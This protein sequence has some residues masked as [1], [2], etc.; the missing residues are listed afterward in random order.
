MVTVKDFGAACDGVTDDS[1][2]FQSA[3]NSV[4]NGST[5][6]FRIPDNSTCVVNTSPSFGTRVL[7]WLVQPG[8]Q[9]T[10]TGV[11][12][13]TVGSTGSDIPGGLTSRNTSLL[14]HFNAALNN[15]TQSVVLIGDSETQ[16]YYATNRLTQSWAALLTST[17]QSLYGNHGLGLIPLYDTANY[18]WTAN[19]TWTGSTTIGP[20]EPS[21]TISSVFSATGTGAAYS[22]TVS[23]SLSGLLA[24]SFTVLTY[25]ASDSGSCAV[26][27]DGGPATVLSHAPTTPAAPVTDVVAAGGLGYHSIAVGPNGATQK[28]YFAGVIPT[29]GTTGLQVSNI[30]ISGSRTD[31]YG[32]VTGS[33]GGL[34]FLPL[35]SP[36]LVI[37]SIGIN[38]LNNAVPLATLTTYYTNILNAA[39]ATGASIVIMSEAPNSIS[40]GNATWQSYRAALQS[41]A[42]TYGAAFLDVTARWKTYAAANAAGYINNN[43]PSTSGHNDIANYLISSLFPLAATVAQAPPLLTTSTGIIPSTP[44]VYTPNTDLVCASGGDPTIG[45]QTVTAAT[46][47]TNAVLTVASTTNF[48]I[49]SRV[50]LSGFTDAGW[51]GTSYSVTANPTTTTITISLN[52]SALSFTGA[53]SPAISLTCTNGADSTG[54]TQQAFQTTYTVPA[55]AFSGQGKRLRI[56][57]V[58]KNFAPSNVTSTFP[59]FRFKLGTTTVYFPLG[60]G[61]IAMSGFQTGQSFPGHFAL[62]AMSA[63]SASAPLIGEG[64]FM[65]PSWLFQYVENANAAYQLYNTTAPLLANFAMGWSVTGAG[66]TIAYASGGTATGTGNCLATASGTTNPASDFTAVGLIGVVGGVISGNVQIGSAFTQTNTGSGYAAIPTTWTLSAPASGAASSCSGT[67]TTTGG[68]LV[69]AMGNAMQIVVLAPTWM[70]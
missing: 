18:P 1:A 17:L 14:G 54:S 25:T 44:A 61:S 5:A 69:G 3:V 4:P 19:G 51:N 28:C 43:H 27:I 31:M 70:N 49:G 29:R 41:L 36:D 16:G 7:A 40:D 63:A 50:T 52:S 23:Y 10:G 33:A 57:T 68:T 65:P 55:N 39:Q 42:I 48:P 6:Q 26:S 8:A 53:G 56:D 64:E 47:A 22:P 30:A 38:D 15:P 32:S 34:G 24:D 67:I 37:I 11:L 20:Y 12:P 62:T 66:G 60:A 45:K 13:G 59:V 46:L 2:A 9:I 21:L 58:F 35:L